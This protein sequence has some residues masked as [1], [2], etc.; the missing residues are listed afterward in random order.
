MADVIA[1]CVV[2]EG[3]PMRLMLLPIIFKWQ[4]LLPL[5]LWQMLKPHVLHVAA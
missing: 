4:M 2:V 5:F 3:K 1:M